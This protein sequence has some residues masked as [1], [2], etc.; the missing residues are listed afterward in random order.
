MKRSVRVTVCVVCVCVLTCSRS[1][2]Q[3]QIPE[4][5]D[6]RWRVSAPLLEANAEQLPGSAE[7]PW[8]AVKDPSI[9]HHDGRWHLFCTLRKQKEGD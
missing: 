1:K 2:L 3:G 5:G 9:I 7:H 6:F 8:V 4:K